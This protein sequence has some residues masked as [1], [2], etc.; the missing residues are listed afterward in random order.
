MDSWIEELQWLHTY[1][2][3]SLFVYSFSQGSTSARQDRVQCFFKFMNIYFNLYLI[4]LY[5]QKQGVS[6]IKVRRPL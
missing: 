3:Q 4:Y 2:F 1:L 5:T 6:V